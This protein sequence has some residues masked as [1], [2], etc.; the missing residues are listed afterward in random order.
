MHGKQNNE[1]MAQR[2]RGVVLLARSAKI[3][4]CVRR[5]VVARRFYEFRAFF[6]RLYCYNASY[7]QKFLTFHN[8]VAYIIL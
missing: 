6:N 3:G 1:M 2:A 8:M 7:T 5:H 4:S